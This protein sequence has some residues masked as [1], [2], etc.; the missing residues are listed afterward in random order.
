MYHENGGSCERVVMKKMMVE[1][2][3]MVI[4]PSVMAFCKL[5]MKL[6]RN[7]MVERWLSIL[8]AEFVTFSLGGYR[9]LEIRLGEGCESFL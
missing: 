8:L 7:S 2:G 6:V 3:S 4:F 9:W 5:V 1:R